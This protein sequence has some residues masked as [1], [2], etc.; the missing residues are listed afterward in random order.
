ME[1]VPAHRVGQV[2]NVTLN[3]HIE[4]MDKIAK[5]DANVKMVEIVIMSLEGAIV[6]LDG[7][8]HCKYSQ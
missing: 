2:N 4:A 7:M 1:L 3:A 6:Q 8:E 5:K